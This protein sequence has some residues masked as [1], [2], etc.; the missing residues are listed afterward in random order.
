MRG[1]LGT[2]I[3]H[4]IGR[5]LPSLIIIQSHAKNDIIFP[6]VY[7]L[8]PFSSTKVSEVGDDHLVS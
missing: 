2:I 7:V 8:H 1:F 5:R 4:N 3:D 6:W